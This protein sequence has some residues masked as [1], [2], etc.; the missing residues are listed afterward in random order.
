MAS[1]ICDLG[2]SGATRVSCHLGTALQ[3]L[4]HAQTSSTT[5]IHKKV[6]SYRKLRN[7]FRV[8]SPILKTERMPI[9]LE[10]VSALFL[11]FA[12]ISSYFHLHPHKIGAGMEVEVARNEAAKL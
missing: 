1:T 12:P 8:F 6:H 11:T 2:V 3:H 10:H 5:T 7:F 4:T 9:M